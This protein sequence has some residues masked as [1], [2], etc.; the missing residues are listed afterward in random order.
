VDS[1]F[2]LWGDER[3]ERGHWNQ[4]QKVL[5]LEIHLLKSKGC[6]SRCLIE[7]V[8]FGFV[9]YLVVEI[10][11]A[12]KSCCM[13]ECKVFVKLDYLYNTVDL[14]PTS[15][16]STWWQY[17]DNVIIGWKLHNSIQYLHSYKPSFILVVTVEY[18]ILFS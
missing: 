2:G 14:L 17:Y 13:K 11:I 18:V 8:M 6:L 3:V 15:I 5:Q 1:V 12:V 9:S 16:L 4:I 7:L 10:P